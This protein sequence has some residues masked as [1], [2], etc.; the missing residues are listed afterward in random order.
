MSG[1]ALHTFPSYTATP[2]RH[3]T[4]NLQ[5]HIELYTDLRYIALTG[6]NAI[7]DARHDATAQL[8]QFAA[9][10]FVQSE[11]EA[12]PGEWTDRPHPDW[13]GDMDDNQLLKKP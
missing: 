2:P 5:R 4:K 13:A 10:Y 7:G 6:T 9:D 11:E 1:T 3:K 12:A 8:H